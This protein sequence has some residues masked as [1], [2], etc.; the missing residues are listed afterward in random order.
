MEKYISKC[1]N[2]VLAQDY[3]NIEAII[4]NDGSTDK[5]EDVC[6]KY[7]RMDE[8]IKIFT[9]SNGGVAEATNMGLDMKTGD[10]VLFLDSD[11][12]LP[13]TAIGKM[14]DSM[15]QENVDIV[16]G[17]VITET[18]T[19]ERLIKEQ[20]EE[21]VICDRKEILKKHLGE[22]II[23]GNLAQKLFK[24]ELFEDVRMPKGRNLADVSTMLM[25][26]TKCRTYKIISDISYVAVKRNNSVSWS[27]LNDKGY[28]DLMFYIDLIGQMD[29]KENEE[30]SWCIRYAKMKML[31]MCYNR[32]HQSDKIT[33]KASKKKEVFEKYS[34]TYEMWKRENNVRAVGFKQ[35]VKMKVFRS[36]PKLY[37]AMMK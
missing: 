9:R 33:G 2:S 26:L 17:G 21:Q 1:L 10:Y 36:A 35:R 4:V 22:M 7:A 24:A 32:L 19:G 25:V 29:T 11:D 8:R 30:I 3:T 31:I 13:N 12:Y 18:E 27:R 37:V 14:V 20:Y 5:T 34:M 16:Q 6:R 15:Q 23:G 28:E